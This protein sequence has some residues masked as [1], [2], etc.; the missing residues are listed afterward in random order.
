MKVLILVF[1]DYP[2]GGA[3][4][5]H[6]QRIALGLRESGAQSM[7]IS[8][9]ARDGS[10]P[11]LTTDD[12]GIP[13]HAVPVGRPWPFLPG[14]VNLLGDFGR[15]AA[16][17]LDDLLRGERWDAIIYYGR[18]WL[19]AS[20]LNAVARRHRVP[21][22][23]YQVEWHGLNAQLLF[24]GQSLDTALYRR[25]ILPKA[26]GIVGISTLW[27]RWADERGIPSVVIPSFADVA[28][29][30]PVGSRRDGQAFEVVFVGGWG[31]RELPLTLFDGLERAIAR[32]VDVRLTVVGEIKSAGAEGH[33][34]R[35]FNRRSELKSRATFTGW[36]RGRALADQLAR[37]HAFVL[38]RDETRET[39]A[40]FPTRLPEYLATANP[41]I[42]SRAG[43]LP[44]YLGHQKS[45]FLI[46]PGNEPGALADAIVH[47]AGHEDERRA[48]GIG[49]WRVAAERL[50]TRRLGAELLDFLTMIMPHEVGAPNFVK[51][52]KLN[53][54]PRGAA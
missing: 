21:V 1:C 48:I 51:E 43:D 25:L 49:G 40:L 27:K 19:T 46:P 45:A 36:L 14:Y 42:V 50:S 32:G 35:D 30:P 3:A 41:V 26:P 28:A 7:I 2:G 20:P 11:R 15:H 13:F 23:P 29:S 33:A 44:L 5:F 47:F 16:G 38:L 39:R 10:Q 53:S 34:L 31:G 9:R 4:A 52:R 22:I 6:A 54:L 18:S 17:F 24:S 37:A 12:R 8:A